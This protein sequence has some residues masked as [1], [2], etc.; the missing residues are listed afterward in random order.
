MWHRRVLEELRVGEHRSVNIFCDNQSAL[1]IAKNHV[2]HDRTKHIEID[3][4]FISEK[5]DD[6]TINLSYIPTSHHVADILTKA[7]PRPNF[8]ELCSK[9]D[10]RSI[11]HQA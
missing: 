6:G 2:Q 3:R 1:S 7:L 8:Q 5:I 4:H 10:F 9:L 11:Y